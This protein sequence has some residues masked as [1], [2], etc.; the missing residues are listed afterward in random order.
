MPA[1]HG[2]DRQRLQAPQAGGVILQIGVV[3][4]FD[5]RPVVD[6]VAAEQGFGRRFIQADAAR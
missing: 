4:V 6:D 2:V 3:G 1:M 5:Q